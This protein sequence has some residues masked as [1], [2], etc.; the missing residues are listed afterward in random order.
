MM[1]LEQVQKRL[2]LMNLTKVSENVGINY[3]LLWKIANNKMINIPHKEVV[4]LSEY[5][6][7]LIHVS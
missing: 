2:E 6:E 5:L 3:P 7:A 1:T 4:L